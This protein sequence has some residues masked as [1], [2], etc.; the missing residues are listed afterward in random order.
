MKSYIAGCKAAVTFCWSNL[1]HPVFW[2][3][4]HSFIVLTQEIDA[5]RALQKHSLTIKT[6][7]IY[8]VQWISGAE[9]AAL[10]GKWAWIKRLQAWRSSVWQRRLAKSSQ[11]I[12]KILDKHGL[13]YC[14]D[15]VSG[16]LDEVQN[17]V[18]LEQALKYAFRVE[19]K[20]TSSDRPY[21]DV[22]Y[23]LCW[24]HELWSSFYHN[25]VNRRKHFT[26]SA[27]SLPFY[28]IQKVLWKKTLS[29]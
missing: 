9:K 1:W 6:L 23:E 3:N 2:N 25:E 18:A 14:E 7:L 4:A 13:S 11:K 20:W 10:V 17:R 21:M 8:T 26:R 5:F 24:N 16:H 27:A 28:K 29:H 12:R 19:Q 15:F 22:I